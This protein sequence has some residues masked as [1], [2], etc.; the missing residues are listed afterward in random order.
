MTEALRTATDPAPTP[1]TS[2]AGPASPADAAREAA[3]A[4]E[5]AA[6]RADRERDLRTPHGWLSLTG[7]LWPTSE[8]RRL[9]GL[10]GEW[11]VVDR[12]LYTRPAPDDTAVLTGERVAEHG[13]TLVAVDEGRSRVL[14][15]FLPEDRA[16]SAAAAGKG[17]DG[18]PGTDTEEVVVEVVLRTG[19]YGLRPRDPRA[20]TRTGFTG[21]PA[22][23]HDPEWVLDARVSWYD[24]PE[25][26]TVGAAQPRLVHHVQVIGEVGVV[27]GGTVT[28][29]ALTGTLDEPTLLFS[30]EADDVA[31]WRVLR[32]DLEAGEGE[33]GTL[34]LDL[35]RAVNLPYAFTEFGT[36]PA[37]VPGNHLP[38]A[39]TA[40]EKA[41]R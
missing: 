7:L 5:L 15:T 41:P 35:N 13:P 39:V 11:W 10:P 16:G 17:A 26:V 6:W 24:E 1:G 30:D 9:P 29:L 40:G 20:A 38:F 37:P 27:H 18:A 34:R 33:Q 2:T 8:P 3:A 12:T 23:G 36:C 19:R 25:R 32:I 28:T 21:V 4:R 31:P 14:G 22:F